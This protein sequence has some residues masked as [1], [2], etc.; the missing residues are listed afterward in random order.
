MQIQFQP[1]SVLTAS[2]YW[3]GPDLMFL[4]NES[5]SAISSPLGMYVAGI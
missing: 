3:A 1:V 5:G 4:A 2:R